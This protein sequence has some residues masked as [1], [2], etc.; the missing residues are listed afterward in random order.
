MR[1]SAPSSPCPPPPPSRSPRPVRPPQPP[2]GRRRAPPPRRTSSRPRSRPGQFK[3]LASLLEQAG[4]AETLAGEEPVHGLRPDRRGVRQGAQGHAGRTREGQGQAARRP[5][6][7]RRQGQADRGEGRQAQVDQ[8]AQRR[9]RRVRV[10]DGKV[11]VGGARV[12]TPDVARLQR[13]HPRHQ[14]GAD[15][16]LK[17]PEEVVPSEGGR[18]PPSLRSGG[19]RAAPPRNRWSRRRDGRALASRLPR[20]AAYKG[21]V[22]H[23]PDGASEVRAAVARSGDG[24]DRRPVG[25][26]DSSSQPRWPHRRTCGFPSISC[27]SAA[28]WRTSRVTDRST[29]TGSSSPAASEPRFPSSRPTTRRGRRAC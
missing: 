24:R 6:L 13:R 18:R 14:Q 9:A 27:A 15:P 19:M 22:A 29:V 7:P 28:I 23:E 21:C 12:T 11:Y 4:L 1:R 17:A 26:S 3:T 2:D 25:S 5:A 20:R 10:R 8:D 16:P